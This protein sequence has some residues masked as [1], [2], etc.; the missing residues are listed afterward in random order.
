VLITPGGRW[1]EHWR[2]PWLCVDRHVEALDGCVVPGCEPA[3]MRS[4]S[5]AGT[6]TGSTQSAV[7]VPKGSRGVETHRS[8]RFPPA[9]LVSNPVVM[10]AAKRHHE[11]IADLAAKRTLLR[12]P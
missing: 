7:T 10:A 12:E 2:Y 6:E 4:G 3:S 8:S 1:P 11:L 9:H 5:E